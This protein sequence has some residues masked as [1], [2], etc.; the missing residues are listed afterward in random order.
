MIGQLD[1]SKER[2]RVQKPL[3]NRNL[4]RL[5]FIA[6]INSMTFKGLALGN[7]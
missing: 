6:S 2:K 3:I 4:H 1:K 5:S 7:Q